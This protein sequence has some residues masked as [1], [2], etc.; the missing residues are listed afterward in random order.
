ML[1]PVLQ[2]RINHKH[3]NISFRKEGLKNRPYNYI[4]KTVR[5]QLYSEILKARL[6][7]TVKNKIST[8]P[9]LLNKKTHRRDRDTLNRSKQICHMS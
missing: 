3:K 1:L 4:S 2:A 9:L 6:P 8:P 5:I 7:F